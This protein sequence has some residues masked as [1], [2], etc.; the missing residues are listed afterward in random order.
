MRTLTLAL[1]L[2]TACSSLNKPPTPGRP[3]VELFQQTALFFGSSSTA[4]LNLSVTIRNPAKE[5]IV[6]RRIRVTAGMGMTQYSVRP[7]ERLFRETIG[8]GE[9]KELQIT[10][11]AYTDRNRLTPTEPLGLRTLVDY[12]SGGK[13]HQELYVTLVVSQ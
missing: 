3:E 5:P 11:T 10:A 2:L 8:P 6:I 12:E 13:R 7:A 9:S 1:A 4:P